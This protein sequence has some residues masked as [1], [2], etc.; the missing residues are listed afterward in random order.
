MDL[1]EIPHERFST[2]VFDL[3]SRKWMLLT[4]GDFKSGDFNPMT[5]SGGFLGFI[6]NKPMAMVVVREQRH[7]L[8]FLERYPDFTL[9]AFPETFKEKLTFCG[10]KSG[11]DCD[12]VKEAGLIPVAASK[13]AAPAFEGAELVFECRKVYSGG[14]LDP[15]GFQFPDVVKGFY[16]ENDYHLVFWGEVLA[17]RGSSEYSV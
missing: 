17:V 2:G 12:K 5:I 11:K 6:W 14:M 1:R 7:T 9:C 13:V 16:P 10:S 15:K 4:A 8:K 3:F